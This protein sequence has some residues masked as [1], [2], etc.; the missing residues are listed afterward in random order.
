[1]SRMITE[2]EAMKF[3]VQLL[4]EAGEPLSMEE[5]RARAKAIEDVECRDGM[6]RTLSKMRFK[7]LIQGKLDIQRK[8]WLWWVE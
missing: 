5:I 1:M 2:E 8:E 7:K 3:I 4:K 6:P